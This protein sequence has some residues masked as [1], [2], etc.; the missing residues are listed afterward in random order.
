M[1][2]KLAPTGLG[3]GIDKDGIGGLAAITSRALKIIG[4]GGAGTKQGISYAARR[5]KPLR[6]WGIGLAFGGSDVSTASA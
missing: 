4:I 6:R 2:L 1:A 5:S 3:S